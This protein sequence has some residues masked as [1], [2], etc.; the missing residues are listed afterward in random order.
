MVQKGEVL[1]NGFTVKGNQKL[2][3]RDDVTQTG[4]QE[5]NR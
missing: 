2:G 3:D 5:I 1:M 4:A